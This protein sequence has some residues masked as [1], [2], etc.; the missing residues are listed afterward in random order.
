MWSFQT[1]I[2]QAHD[3]DMPQSRELAEVTCTSRLLITGHHVRH[4]TCSPS[5]LVTH[6]I[7]MNPHLGLFTPRPLQVWVPEDAS[8]SG[9]PATGRPVLSDRDLDRLTAV[10]AAAANLAPTAGTAAGT[11]FAIPSWWVMC[12]LISSLLITGNYVPNVLGYHSVK[13]T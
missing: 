4:N 13:E 11:P 9:A 5:P 8:G 10:A 2:S 6:P 3:A 1:G 7:L 12:Q